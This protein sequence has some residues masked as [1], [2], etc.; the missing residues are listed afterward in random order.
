MS[1]PIEEIVSGIIEAADEAREQSEPYKDLFE[2]TDDLESL[3]YHLNHKMDAHVLNACKVLKEKL[4]YSSIP[5]EAFYILLATPILIAKVQ[6]HIAATQGRSCCA[7]KARYHV[8]SLLREA[9][10]ASTE[11]STDE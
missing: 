9:L 5:D 6:K 7:D 1:N 4:G 2:S 3:V 10:P 11:R 8:A